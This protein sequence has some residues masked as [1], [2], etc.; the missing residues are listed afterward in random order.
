MDRTLFSPP[1]IETFKQ[2]RRAYQFAFGSSQVDKIR[3]STLC[4]RFLLRALSEIH[5]GRVANLPQVQ[6]YLGQHWPTEKLAS[7]GD[8][9]QQEKAVQAFRFVYRVLTQYISAP[10]KPRGSEIA[11]VNQK[12]RARVPHLKV[13]LEET[14][15]LILWHPERAM[16][17]I[18][19]FHLHPLKPFDPAW[20]TP[21]LL[22]RYYLAQRLKARWPFQKLVFTFCR[23]QTE[24]VVP[25]TIEIEESVFR[26]HWPELLKTLDQM[27][28]PDDYAPHRSPLC[29]RCQFLSECNAMDQTTP[30][31][32]PS[33]S[34]SLTA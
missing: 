5:R 29:K 28:N 11:A 25:V 14:L 31:E 19:D 33:S 8:G 21:S 22:V 20:P 18:V 15:D 7:E 9:D 4:K 16:L 32:T 12:V 23:L 1:M 13:Y 3:L 24:G 34:V 6:K 27:K 17:E 2:C 10:Y 26:L 30:S